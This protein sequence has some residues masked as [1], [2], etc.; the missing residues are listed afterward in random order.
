M[1]YVLHEE[2]CLR[3]GVEIILLNGMVAAKSEQRRGWTI[4]SN[5]NNTIDG[6]NRF[7]GHSFCSNIPYKGKASVG[8]V[9]QNANVKCKR[10]VN[11]LVRILNDSPHF[12]PTKPTWTR[13]FVILRSMQH[14]DD[15]WS[16]ALRTFW[17]APDAQ[18]TICRLRCKHIR[19]LL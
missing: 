10:R 18:I 11:L 3:I 2:W 8:G 9:S 7:I 4:I 12:R 16:I 15:A 13:Y 6:R 5:A 19:F 14:T 1:L 17:D